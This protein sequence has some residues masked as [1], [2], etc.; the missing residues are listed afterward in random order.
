M[1]AFQREGAGRLA[2]L[3]CPSQHSLGWWPAHLLASSACL[4]PIME[5][6]PVP[7]EQGLRRRQLGEVSGEGAGRCRVSSSHCIPAHGALEKSP[8]G[9]AGCTWRLP[10]CPAVSESQGCQRT[11]KTGKCSLE[12]D[13][14][15]VGDLGWVCLLSLQCL[16][17]CRARN[18]HPRP[19][20]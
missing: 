9:W 11:D 13:F 16:E 18:G 10:E 12:G 3:W 19:N 7:D 6:R 17:Q 2:E 8:L 15:R 1:E 4:P 14:L 5:R 20:S